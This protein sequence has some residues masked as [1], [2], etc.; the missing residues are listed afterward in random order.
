MSFENQFPEWKNEG[1]PPPEELQTSGFKGAQKPPAA[2]LNWLC[3]LVSKCVTELQT[4]LTA[5]GADKENPH[6]V[7]AAQ[8]GLDKVDN[9]PDYEKSVNTA[10]FA[11][12]A[13]KARQMLNALIVRFKGGST[14]GTDQWTFDGGTSKSINITA[15]K[16]GAA[17]ADHAHFTSQLVE[18]DGLHFARVLGVYSEDGISYAGG[19]SGLSELYNGLEITVIPNVTSA[20]T[21][22][23]L[24]LN[25]FGEKPVRVPYNF[26]TSAVTTPK[27]PTFF[28]EGNP[29]RLVYR[30]NQEI[31]IGGEKITGVWVT[32]DKE[33][34]SAGYLTGILSVANG[35]TGAD[36]V[37][38]AL[39]NLGLGTYN[40]T[41]TDGL[42]YT[43]TAEG[44]S[45]LYNGL[46]ITIV[47]NMA[48][49]DGIVTLDV[50]GLGAHSIRLALSFN[51]SA[52]NALKGNYLAAGRPIKLKYDANCNLGVQGMGAW[53][54][55]D[56]QKT[57]AQDLYG[58]VP[59]QNG[60]TYANSETTAQHKK[61]ALENLGISYGEEL[62]TS[63]VEGQI[64]FKKV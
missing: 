56:R 55:A 15:E 61:A 2:W 13:G 49:A 9:T 63:G 39:E 3:S 52:T 25:E 42:A 50:N 57:S 62:P 43:V 40:A 32:A 48:N 60:G 30:A 8:V 11:S 6:G 21:T 4:K 17:T 22:I 19:V 33:V 14:E 31:M 38:E 37:A 36:N 59:I 12:E 47:P 27:L 29:V 24:N 26:N 5:H 1:T 28:G 18:T 23:T 20:S 64:F 46:E 58:S 51:C 10:N 44:V 41:S 53:I 54:F 16:I 7:T 45:A 34:T 35:G